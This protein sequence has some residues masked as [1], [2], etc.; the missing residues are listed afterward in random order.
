VATVT[1]R[2]AF[3]AAQAARELLRISSAQRDLRAGAEMTA[4][5]TRFD[6]SLSVAATQ[7]STCYRT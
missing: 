4:A 5:R 1:K 3:S 2:D 7:R 6:E